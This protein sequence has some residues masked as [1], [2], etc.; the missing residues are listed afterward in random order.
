M[1]ELLGIGVGGFLAV[2]VISD[3]LVDGGPSGLV[4]TL[5]RRLGRPV[6]VVAPSDTPAVKAWLREHA[7][8][9]DLN[10]ADVAF[11][12]DQLH[13]AYRDVGEGK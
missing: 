2:S 11:F 7:G 3:F 10:P 5:G 4:S 13:L 6:T 1:L 12:E 9:T 8:T